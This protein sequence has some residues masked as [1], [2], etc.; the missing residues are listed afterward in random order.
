MM[1]HRPQPRARTRDAPEHMSCLIA[2]VWLLATPLQP[3]LSF[4]S[5]GPS[6][7]HMEPA[8]GGISWEAEQ[9]QTQEML[10][11]WAEGWWRW[12]KQDATTGCS[13]EKFFPMILPSLM[14]QQ[15]SVVDLEN[16]TYCSFSSA[17]L[18]D[19]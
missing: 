7:V 12:P 14:T 8:L 15:S 3:Q 13:W 18:R 19:V 11:T 2:T 16:G 6:S 17:N 4:T 9:M 1:C 10:V 5:Q